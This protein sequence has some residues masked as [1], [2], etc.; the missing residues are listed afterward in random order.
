MTRPNPD[1]H[2]RVGAYA[3]C[4]RD[5]CV[6]LTRIWEGDVDAGKWTLPGGGIDFGESPLDGLARE[7][8]EETGLRGDVHGLLDVVDRVY[9]PWRGW[10]PLHAIGAVYAV[11]AEGE[12]H[13]VE[14]G[15]TTVEARWVPL[16]EAD[17]LPLTHLA[18]RGLELVARSRTG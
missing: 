7:L 5:A 13:V 1:P 3:L 4:V 8:Y 2:T 12:P 17:D 16:A 18:T 11:A 6:L 14:Q 15:G 10:G 9:P